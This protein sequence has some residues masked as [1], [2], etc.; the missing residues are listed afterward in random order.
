MPI[1]TSGLVEEIGR[2]EGD[3]KSD[4]ITAFVT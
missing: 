1:H 3:S 4:L 2:F